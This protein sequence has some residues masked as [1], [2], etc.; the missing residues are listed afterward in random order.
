[1]SKLTSAQYKAYLAAGSKAYVE[2]VFHLYVI[3]NTK[4]GAKYVTVRQ[5]L[6]GEA[7]LRI[8]EAD[9]HDDAQRIPLLWSVRKFGINCHSISRVAS[10]TDKTEARTVMAKMIEKLAE[11]GLSLN[12]GRPKVGASSGFYWLPEAEAKKVIAPVLAK[13]N[14]PSKSRSRKP[15]EA[16]TIIAEEAAA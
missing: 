5:N 3:E 4:I 10:Y 15:A 1:M 2:P 9:S 14:Q 16:M 13:A 7:F 8:V 11:A 12:A 6:S